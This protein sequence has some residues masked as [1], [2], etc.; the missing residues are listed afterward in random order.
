MNVAVP[1]PESDGFDDDPAPAT[2]NCTME[3]TGTFE[4]E[5]LV[6]LMHAVSADAFAPL[7]SSPITLPQYPLHEDNE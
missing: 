7:I 4:R 1:V 6:A 3:P 5:Q 2:P